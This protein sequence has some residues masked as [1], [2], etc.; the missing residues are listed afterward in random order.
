MSSIAAPTR[1]LSV[2]AWMPTR[3]YR[4]PST[5]ILIF[6]PAS[7]ISTFRIRSWPTRYFSFIRIEETTNAMPLSLRSTVSPER[8]DSSHEVVRL[9]GFNSGAKQTLTGTSNF[10]RTEARLSIHETLNLETNSLN[11]G[12]HL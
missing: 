2:E 7:S 11:M 5:R 9:C 3:S 10:L 6:L 1:Y 4:L 8:N 12:D